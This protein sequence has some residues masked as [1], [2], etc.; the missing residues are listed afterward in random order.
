MGGVSSQKAGKTRS[1][2]QRRRVTA[3]T[4]VPEPEAREFIGERH[5]RIGHPPYDGIVAPRMRERRMLNKQIGRAQR[6]RVAC[7][8]T[9]KGSDALQNADRRPVDNCR[10]RR[11]SAGRVR[12]WCFRCG[13]PTS[14]TDLWRRVRIHGRSAAPPASSQSRAVRSAPAPICRWA[15]GRRS[16]SW[17]GDRS[18]DSNGTHSQPGAPQSPHDGSQDAIQSEGSVHGCW[19]ASDR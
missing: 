14:D 16:H 8:P 13:I 19:P 6:P 3:K 11:A 7:A 1:R 9:A 4:P 2:R 12:L 15:P 5:R 17:A 10:R 18:A